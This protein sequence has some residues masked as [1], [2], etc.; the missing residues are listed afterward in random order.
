MNASSHTHIH[1]SEFIPVIG[2]RLAVVTRVNKV[3]HIRP[4]KT[5]IKTQARID[6]LL[7]VIDCITFFLSKNLVRLLLLTGSHLMFGDNNT[8]PDK[9]V[10]LCLSKF[11]QVSI[12][13]RWRL[14]TSICCE[15]T[16]LFA[17]EPIREL[18]CNLHDTLVLV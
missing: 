4:D 6:L 11:I 17:D 1:S 2:F 8:D 12:E 18:M 9:I 10:C 5:F 14:V 15:L 16:W 7:C 3:M 13:K